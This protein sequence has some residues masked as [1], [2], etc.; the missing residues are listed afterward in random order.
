MGRPLP[1]IVSYGGVN[2]A[3][4][5]SSQHAHA[6]LIEDNLS[7]TQRDVLFAS[8]RQ[9]T[10]SDGA[11]E[12]QLLASTLIRRIGDD[13]FDPARVAWNQAFNVSGSEAPTEFILPRKRVPDPLPEHWELSETADEL[14]VRVRIHGA[15]SLLLPA[16]RDF[17]VKAASQLPSGFDPASLYPSRNHPRGLAMSIFAASDALGNL[18]MNW[19]NLIRQVPPDLISVYAGSSMGQLDDR[20]FGGM[21][22]SRHRG[23]R[24][25]SKQCPLGMPQM[26]ADFINAYVLGT[27]GA[28]GATIGACASFL[29]NLRLAVHDIQEGRARI[30]VVG[31]AEAPI[32][33]ETMDGYSAMGALATDKGLRALDGFDDGT[34]PD[35]RRACRPFADNCGF[36]MGESSQYVILFD[37]ALALETGATIFASIPDVFVHADGPKKSISSPGV[38]NYLTLARAAA[39]ARS[40]LGEE[41]LRKAGFVQAHGTG[42]PQNRVTES[43][44]LSKVARAFGIEDW[45]VAAIKCYVGHSLAAASGDQLCMTLGTWATGWIPGISSSAAIADDVVQQGLSFCLEHRE[46]APEQRAYALINAKGFGGNNASATVIDPAQTERLLRQRYGLQS[47]LD[48][49]RKQAVTLGEREEWAADVLAGRAS[50]R[51]RFDEGVLGDDDVHIEEDSLLLAGQRIDLNYTNPYT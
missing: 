26:P 29:Y 41:L 31:A 47:M 25:T 32:N 4:R 19:D 27:S 42:T 13:H 40:V 24:V 36:T 44:I 3:G 45:P 22:K 14:S 38:G 33:A 23:G 18:G 39:C 20:G 43:A 35:Y 37:D 50:V 9:L 46:L 51:Y 10:G 12:K 28:T 49:E 2:S 17:D 11:S 5:S 21:I 16:E 34:A 8:L 48:W 30:A 7:A 15:Q 1:V 6:R